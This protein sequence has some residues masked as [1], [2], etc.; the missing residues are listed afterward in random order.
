MMSG[1]KG[2][3]PNAFRRDTADCRR[4]GALTGIAVFAVCVVS[5]FYDPVR[6]PAICLVIAALIALNATWKR[7]KARM[8]H[9][10]EDADFLLCLECG[11]DLR[12]QA[13]RRCPECGTPFQ[14]ADLRRQWQQWLTSGRL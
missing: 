10:L 5:V 2:D 11:Y 14:P 8:Q 6:L 9:R 1:M 13:T 3:V 4:A 7:L 12:G